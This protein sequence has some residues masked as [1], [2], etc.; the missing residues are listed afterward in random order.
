MRARMLLIV[1]ALFVGGGFWLSCQ[2]DAARTT[3]VAPSREP[4][5]VG[6]ETCKE[7][8][9]G[10]HE[11]WLE[12]AHA[13]ALRA[14]SDQVVDGDFHGEPIKHQ[15]FI[16]TPYQREGRYFI[17]VEGLDGRPDG[18]HAVTRVIGRSFEQAYL[19]TDHTGRWR[20]LPICWSIERKEW[21][22]THEILE[23]I[24][25]H[26][27]AVADDYDSRNHVFNHGCGQCHATDYDVG[28][29]RETGNL[30][31]T[32]LEGAVACES[33]HG[34]GSV[35]VAFHEGD[36]EP[37]ET[38]V[39]PERLVH[40]K[41]DL[42]DAEPVLQSCGRCHYVHR[43]KYAIDADPRIGF[44]EISMTLNFDQPGFY[45]DGRLSGL[46]YHGSTQS[47]S[48]CFT[49]GNMSCLHCHQMHGGEKFAMKWPG[50][51][52]QQ[53]AKCHSLDEYNT[54][55]HTHHDPALVR[56][57]DCH[58]PKFLTGVL[59]FLRDHSIR[60]PDPYLTEKHGADSVPNAC[61][62]CHNN[63]SA[64]WAREHREK[65]WGPGDATLRRNVDLVMRLRSRDETVTSDELRTM[66]AD[67]ESRGFFRFTALNALSG[68]SE[69][70]YEPNTQ[71]LAR[72]LLQGDD[73][74]MLQLLT[75]AYSGYRKQVA[76]KE[77]MKLLDHPVRTVRVPAAFALAR[78]GWRGGH[79]IDEPMR[80]AFEDARR[81]LDRQRA[82]VPNLEMIALLADAVG[83]EEEARATFDL[84]LRRYSA[85]PGE[86]RP[87]LLELLQRLARGFTEKGEHQEALRLYDQV[88]RAADRMVPDSLQLD[89]ADSIEAT[90]DART[91][92][93]VWGRV[94]GQAEDESPESIL[95][96]ARLLA[97]RGKKV[98]A[99]ER[100]LD[101]RD[102]LRKDPVGGDH[103]RRVEW[104][105]RAVSR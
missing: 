36:E 42:R 34:P 73:T 40:P 3:V 93:M 47:Q 35:H 12:T 57:V 71:A 24:A 82:T 28:E 26:V 68:K 59:H 18:D 46:N 13:Y 88:Q 84:I 17:R 69:W 103:L 4:G 101:L 15:F 38:Y 49:E 14:P 1:F 21:D 51:S 50:D 41:K 99:R 91:A 25:G 97:G 66:L 33:C 43:W 32:F 98:D 79:D 52:D 95:A 48:A 23:D 78:A 75:E 29:D 76:A 31:S 44:E 92:E 60:S 90:G 27:G 20:V 64:T 16:A 19:T 77:L 56:C 89:A 7:C 54:K 80:R 102:R 86:W 6:S 11:T 55:A 37:D 100:L 2:Q 94:L 65:L 30:N 5:F 8:H 96:R 105:L 81:M 85:A 70:W 72:R 61:N 87:A 74:E 45:A 10:R 22:F 9:E 53:C 39:W 58:M 62:V 63:E 104:A 83:E 67:E